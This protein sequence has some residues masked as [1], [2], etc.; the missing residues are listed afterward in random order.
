MYLRY[1]EMEPNTKIPAEIFHSVLLLSSLKQV[2]LLQP[3]VKW[4]TDNK[5]EPDF[6]EYPNHSSQSAVPRHH[7]PLN[8][9]HLDTQT[10]RHLVLPF[11]PEVLV[12]IFIPL[13]DYYSEAAKRAR[14]AR[15]GN[16]VSCWLESPG[17]KWKQPTFARTSFQDYRPSI[18]TLRG[19]I[20]LSAQAY[21]TSRWFCNKC[22]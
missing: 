2:F 5:K 15:S 4:K 12:K 7:N 10:L 21:T 19:N 11:R 14:T 17:G 9:F 6:P 8:H 1:K 13:D 3:K 16:T 22:H 20:W 18:K